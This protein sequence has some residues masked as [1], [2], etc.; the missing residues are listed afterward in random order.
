MKRAARVWQWELPL[1]SSSEVRGRR[2]CLAFVAIGTSRCTRPR[3][4]FDVT[5]AEETLPT[6]NRRRDRQVTV[7]RKLAHPVRDAIENRCA[8]GGGNEFVFPHADS[9]AG[10]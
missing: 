3:E 6:P 7:T 1:D 9:M 8:L 10:R 2:S 5:T 4:L